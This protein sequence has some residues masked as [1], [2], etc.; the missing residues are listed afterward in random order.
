MGDMTEIIYE[1]IDQNVESPP[2]VIH[3]H[4]SA[5]RDHPRGVGD[6]EQHHDGHIADRPF[7]VTKIPLETIHV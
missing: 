6:A 5:F 2:A 4:L 7:T 3:K 1:R